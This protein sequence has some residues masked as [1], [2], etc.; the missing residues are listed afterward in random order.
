MVTFSVPLLLLFSRLHGEEKDFELAS[1]PAPK[2]ND[3]KRSI[4]KLAKAG[5]IVGVAIMPGLLSG[6]SS[7]PALAL[8]GAPGEGTCVQCH[9]GPALVGPTVIFPSTT[10]T[11]GGPAVSWTINSPGG[12]GGFEL[13][14]RP[15]PDTAQAG[16]LTAGDATSDVA[17]QAGI[18]YA[19]HFAR[20]ASWVVNWTPPATNIGSL[21]VFVVAVDANGQVYA[22]KYALTPVVAPPQGTITASPSALTFNYGGTALATQSI[23]VVSSGVSIAFTSSVTTVTGGTWLS[24]APPG[25]GTPAGVTVTANP[26]GLAIGQYTGTVTVTAP[27][28]TNGPQTVGVT[29]NVTAVPPPATTLTASPSTLTFNY[30]GV[31]LATQSIQVGSSGTA[32]AFTTAAVTASGGRLVD[33]RC[34]GRQYAGEYYGDGQSRRFGYGAVHGDRDCDRSDGQQ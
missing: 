11:P 8:T 23:Q 24:V 2:R 34:N 17:I 20:A 30:S 31:L 32:L 22:T 21:T 6:H 13:S 4:A 33:G 9:N 28:A 12:L 26:N 14:V 15:D 18:Q 19:R 29:L 16:T 5:L 10:Y 25:A 1:M 3:E 7:N 27:T